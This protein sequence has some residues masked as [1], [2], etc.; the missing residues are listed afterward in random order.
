MRLVS[1]AMSYSSCIVCAAKY[2][3]TASS[4]SASSSS[5]A[6]FGLNPLQSRGARPDSC[7]ISSKLGI[8]A[9]PPRRPND[10][11]P[12]L[13]GQISRV[14]PMFAPRRWPRSR[15]CGYR[16]GFAMFA[17]STTSCIDTS[18]R[19]ARPVH[20]AVSAAN[21]ASPP[22]CAYAVGSVQRTG[23][24]SGS[25][26]QNM[27][28]LAAIT[29]RSD[30]RHDERGPS[31]PNGVMLTHTASG[32]R[33]GSS[34]SVPARPGESNTMPASVRTASS[35][36]SWAASARTSL[37]A[38][39]ARA[40]L[41]CSTSPVGGTTRTTTAPQSPSTPRRSRRRVTADVDDAYIVQETFAHEGW[42]VRRA[43][44]G[45]SCRPLLDPTSRPPCGSST[46]RSCPTIPT[47]TNCARSQMPSGRKL[48]RSR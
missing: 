40:T 41:P 16:A 8:R 27:L 1:H 26:V 36:G 31:R 25:P 22:V 47:M 15:V 2:F 35:A 43:Y 46:T 20:S 42:S 38:F 3:P 44:A 48:R 18:T 24:R 7:V 32:A 14:R 10:T 29:P 45:R 39:H 6:V 19:W 21:A 11:K 37:P 33:A 4:I 13:V 23:A 9:L 5:L 12:S 34:C 30:A 17:I 28:P